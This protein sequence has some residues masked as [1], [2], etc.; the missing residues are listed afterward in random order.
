MEQKVDTVG[1]LVFEALVSEDIYST[2]QT[3]KALVVSVDPVLY[4]PFTIYFYLGVHHRS[5]CC[6]EV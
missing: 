2:I 1:D 5:P 4:K 6:G 3:L